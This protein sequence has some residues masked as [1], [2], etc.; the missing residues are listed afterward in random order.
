MI[1][2]IRD[3]LVVSLLM[4]ASLSFVENAIVGPDSG[5]VYQG[6][7]FL[8][9]YAAGIG[10]CQAVLQSRQNQLELLGWQVNEAKSRSWGL[11][12]VAEQH[13]DRRIVIQCNWG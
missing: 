1:S 11:V 9:T 3:T 6:Q 8:G 2:N 13:D 10:D 12:L 7:E 5:A 4:I